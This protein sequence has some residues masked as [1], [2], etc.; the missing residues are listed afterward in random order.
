MEI[1]M[2]VNVHVDK[3]DV[4]RYKSVIALSADN[5]KVIFDEAINRS[6]TQEKH[7]DYDKQKLHSL[8]FGETEYFRDTAIQMINGVWGGTGDGESEKK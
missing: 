7:T 3:D 8:L 2:R 1:V 6:I 4:L 5:G